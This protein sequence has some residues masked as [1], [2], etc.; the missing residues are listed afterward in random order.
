MDVNKN[1]QG[2]DAAPNVWADPHSPLRCSSKTKEVALNKPL[3]K[4]IELDEI[5]DKN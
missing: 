3:L 1:G 5:T 2:P 4:C